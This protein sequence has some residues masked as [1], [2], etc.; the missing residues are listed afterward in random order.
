MN[1]NRAQEIAG[2]VAKLAVI[3]TTFAARY[4][5]DY[6]MTSESPAEAWNL[7]HQC[8]AEQAQIAQLLD[9]KSLANAYVRWGK[10]WECRDM[11]NTGLVN[12]MATEAFRLVEHA[13]YLDALG[14]DVRRED[15][16][17]VIQ[18]VIAGLLHPSTRQDDLAQSDSALAEAV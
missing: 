15:G 16:L 2:R 1:V 5:R 10:W 18:E 8:M 9:R 7:Y 4:G 3:A 11:I 17:R 13:A 12:E 6:R 14:S